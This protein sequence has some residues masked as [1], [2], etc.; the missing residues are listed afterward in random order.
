[1]PMRGSVVSPP[2]STTSN[3]ACI[4]ACYAGASC[5]L[6]QLGDEVAGI[7]QKLAAAVVTEGSTRPAHVTA[8]AGIAVVQRWQFRLPASNSR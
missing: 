3:S 2:C 4:A 7:T 5:S 1:M 6:W 8:H